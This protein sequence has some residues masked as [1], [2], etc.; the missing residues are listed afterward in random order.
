MSDELPPLTATGPD[1]IEA[2]EQLAALLDLPSVDVDIRGARITG[3][4][5]RASVQIR[6][7]TGTTMEFDTVRDM[8]RR[9]NLIAEVAACTG[10]C[11]QLKQPQ[12]VRAVALVRALA[13]HTAST[14]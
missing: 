12:A 5:S 13:E 8:V 10:A 4:G 14:T 7:S 11:P 1:P 2:A 6:L 3:Q 9:Q